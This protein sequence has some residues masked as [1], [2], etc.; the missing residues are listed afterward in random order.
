MTRHIV[1][2]EGK[3]NQQDREILLNQKGMVVWLTGLSA[4]GKSTI[5]VELEKILTLE[6]KL[7]LKLDG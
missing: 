1:W 6:G 5:S 3:V 7:V 4:S 2:H